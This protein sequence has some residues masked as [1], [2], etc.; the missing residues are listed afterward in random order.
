M[1]CFQFGNCVLSILCH[2]I[3]FHEDELLPTS[4]LAYLIYFA[5][6]NLFIQFICMFGNI[7]WKSTKGGVDN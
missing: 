6:Y 4:V 7:S 2:R 1:V 3:K 5:M